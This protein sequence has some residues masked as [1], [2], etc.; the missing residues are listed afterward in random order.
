MRFSSLQRRQTARNSSRLIATLCLFL[1]V[2]PAAAMPPP[3]PVPVT[4]IAEDPEA[5]AV[6]EAFL[7]LLRERGWLGDAAAKVAREPLQGCV[8]RPTNQAACVREVQEWK[9]DGQPGVVIVA[10]G[11]PVQ[12]WTCIG[13]AKVAATPSAQAVRID[14]RKAMFGLAKQR[15]HIAQQGRWLYH[16]SWV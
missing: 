3:V 13:V 1:F 16:G 10:D 8:R 4:V 7:T 11:N 5:Q 14:L 15:L 12:H 2:A 6:G 9:K